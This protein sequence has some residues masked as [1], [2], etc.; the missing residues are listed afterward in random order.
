MK[1]LEGKVRVE[2]IWE[3][4]PRRVY[5][6][7]GAEDIRRASEILFGEGLRLITISAVDKGKGIDILYHFSN[8]REGKIITLRATAEKPL[9]EIDSIAAIIPGA[10]DME[11]EIGDLFGVRFKGHPDPRRFILSDDFPEGVYPLRREE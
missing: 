2:K 5:I 6:G 9:C 8:D 4:S 1:E 11:R 3:R 7:V 10:S